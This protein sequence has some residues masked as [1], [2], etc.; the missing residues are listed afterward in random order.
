M[1]RTLGDPGLLAEF[2]ALRKSFHD[3]GDHEVVRFF[4]GVIAEHQRKGG[5]VDQAPSASK[6]L[7]TDL[8]AILRE[9]ADLKK[10]MR[11]DRKKYNSMEDRY[12]RLLAAKDGG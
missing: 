2:R 10:M 3:D 12:R 11:A 7:P 8:A 1:A 4:D 9:I 6:A 5:Q